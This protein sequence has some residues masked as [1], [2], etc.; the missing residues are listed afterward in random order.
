MITN[1]LNKAAGFIATFFLFVHLQAQDKGFSAIE[2]IPETLTTI[3]IAGKVVDRETRTP[4]EFSTITLYSSSDSLTLTGVLSGKDGS[5]SLQTTQRDFFIKAEF[6]GYHPFYLDG[7]TLPFLHS[8]IDI[9]EIGLSINLEQIPTVEIRAERSSVV[10]ALDKRVFNV[11]KDLTSAGG[12]AEDVLRN[13]PGISV[14]NEGRLNLR[15]NSN[16]RMLLNGRASSLVSNENLFGLRQIRASQIERVEIITN[17]SARFEAEG[18]AGIVNIV[19]KKNQEK[20]TNGSVDAHI[21]NNHNAG[22]AGNFN[23][24]KNKF[25]FFLGLGGWHSDTPGNGSFR[26][27]FYNQASSDSTVF[28]NMDRTHRRAATPQFVKFGADFHPNQKNTFNSSFAYRSTDGSSSSDLTYKDALGRPDQYFQITRRMEDEK[29]ISSDLLYSFIYKK[30]FGKKGHQLVADLLYE[31]LKTNRAST[32]EEQYFNGKNQPLNHIDYLQFSENEEGNQRLGVFLDYFQP[33]KKNAKLETGWQSAFREI[34]NTYA[35]KEII[36][37]VESPDINFTNEFIYQETIHGG[38]VNFGKT[39][40]PFTLQAGL[41]VERSDVTT[42]LLASNLTTP[43]KYTNLFPSFFFSYN[44]SEN[45]AFQISYS[46]RIQRPTYRDLNPFFNIRDRRNIFRGNPNIQPEYTDSYE[47]GYI[48]YWQK[49]S[50]SSVAYLRLTD[51]VIK[52]LQRIDS[53]LPGVTITQAENLDYKRN[54]GLEFTC[55]YFPNPRWRVNGDVNFFHSL[56]EGSFVHEGAEIFVGGGSFSMISRASSRFTF[57]K[58]LHLQ[59]TLSYTAPRTT[60]QGVNRATTALDLAVGMDCLKN[61]GSLTL[62][63]NDTFNSRRR[64]TFSED[65]TFYSEDNFLWQTRTILLSFHYRFN[66]RKEPNR[67]YISPLLEEDEREF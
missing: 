16:I 41:R 15:G 37:N 42:R 29:E 2:F 53:G 24:H 10:L 47:L 6:I 67:L 45:Q 8:K 39:F 48:R 3:E 18:M 54:Y 4:L 51:Q 20:G 12:T 1:L 56:S 34:S 50:L 21:G 59:A 43:R 7:T 65:V 13:V 46:R 49:A 36:N 5:F 35:V 44:L 22:L 38:Y 58:K 25:N 55:A 52:R 26:N 27:R 60:T 17:P 28:S 40:H 31:E 57:W 11:G 63:V 30:H 23:Y 61:K 64:R 33:L 32:F 66:Q 62:S 9:G 19:L 14:D